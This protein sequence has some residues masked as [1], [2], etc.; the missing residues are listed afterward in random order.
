[1]HETIRFTREELFEKV[2]TTP[3]LKLAEEIGVSDVALGKACRKANIPL[4]G[5]GYWARD[6]KR[7]QR[8][9]LPAAPKDRDGDVEFR[10]L[11]AEVRAVLPVPPREP[12]ELLVVPEVL[13]NP[14]PLV[15]RTRRLKRMPSQY[16]DKGRIE[17]DY[18]EALFL[19][20]TP[21]SFDRAL[22]V[23]DALIKA[24]EAQGFVW[25]VLEDGKVGKTVIQVDGQAIRVV[26]AEKLTRREVPP[27]PPP[28]GRSAAS[29]WTSTYTRTELAPTGLLS[30]R[31]EEHV[32]V[33]KKNWTDTRN[34]RIE[35]RLHEVI[36]ALPQVAAALKARDEENERQ[37]KRWQA[38]EKR[39]VETAREAEA[40]RRL[41]LRMVRY[42]RSWERANRL[43][44]FVDDIERRMPSL[45]VDREALATWLAWA[46]EQIVEL[47]PVL[48]EPAD[49]L[50][51]D[52]SVPEYFTGYPRYGEKRIDW[53]KPL[54][55]ELID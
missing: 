29:T 21:D 27:D 48:A 41:R 10:V 54:E 37:R 24:S 38:E 34:V 28:K 32:H 46:K 14:H 55:D 6:D 3:L 9:V 42:M 30:F 2:W 18:K 13:T 20:V 51:L 31:I 15:A 40:L 5:R 35:E 45:D 47:D 43:R 39:R 17:L 44:A 19:Q 25:R 7:R 8:P 1:M 22:R 36:D 53:W 12:A 23:M 50:S 26:L 16:S 33:P 4:P 52:V 11:S 49:V